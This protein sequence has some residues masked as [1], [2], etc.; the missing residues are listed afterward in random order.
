MSND[1][2]TDGYRSV[3]LDATISALAQDTASSSPRTISLRDPFDTISP[4]WS[5]G[6][7]LA[8]VADQDVASG[9]IPTSA[10]MSVLFDDLMVSGSGS[11]A[12]YQD[13]LGRSLSVSTALKS[14]LSSKK[15]PERTILHG[16]DGVVYAGEML[17]VLGRPGSGCSTL[18]KTLAGFSEGY[19][20][21]SGDVKYNGVDV[22]A[23][24]KRFRGEV[25]Y[26]AEGKD[27]FA[28]LGN[29]TDWCS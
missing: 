9:K 23:I 2:E 17:L 4:D 24:K 16:I 7:Y 14:L 19:K 8:A 26:N 10:E 18:L 22:S 6:A 1:P 12:T 13:D 15:E 5:Y 11:G 29:K 25:I 21:C 28:A 3:S 27:P 20:S